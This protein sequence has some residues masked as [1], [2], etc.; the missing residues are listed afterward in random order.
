MTRESQKFVHQDP[1]EPVVFEFE[2]SGLW[3]DSDGYVL[4]EHSKIFLWNLMQ[5][6]LQ[7]KEKMNSELSV[8]ENGIKGLESL[9]SAYLSGEKNKD[10]IETVQEVIHQLVQSYVEYF[11]IKEVENIDKYDFSLLLYTNK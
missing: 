10:D 3:K 7:R 1:Q 4:D 2:S 8:L 9:E 5:K 11:G 6:L